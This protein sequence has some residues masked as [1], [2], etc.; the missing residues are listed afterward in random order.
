MKEKGKRFLGMPN[1]ISG[2]RDRTGCGAVK[3][4]DNS[5]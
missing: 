1:I 3:G 5:N 4:Y 2:T